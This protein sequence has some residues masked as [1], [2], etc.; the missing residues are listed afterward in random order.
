[1]TDSADVVVIGSGAGGAP[2]ALELARAGV[3]V[4][5][6]ER[7]KYHKREDFHYDEL[8]VARRDFLVPS[9][10][11]DPHIVMETGKAAERSNEGWIAVCVGGGT[12]HWNWQ[13]ALALWATTMSQLVWNSN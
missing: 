10:R 11:T 8:G 13:V 7:G 12:V 4:V 6:L 5:V 3:K 1:M 9:A 2:L